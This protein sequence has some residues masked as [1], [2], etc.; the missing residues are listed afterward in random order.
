LL[1]EIHEQPE[2][3][4]KTMLSRNMQDKEYVS[5]GDVK[6]TKRRLGHYNKKYIVACGTAYQRTCRQIS[7]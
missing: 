5:L 3:I 1:K 6:I 4:R 7:I 2:G